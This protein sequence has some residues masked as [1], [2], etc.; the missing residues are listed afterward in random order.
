MKNYW[1]AADVEENGLHYAYA[2]RVSE[3]DN[4][5][6]RLDRVQGLYAANILPS[7]KRATEVVAAWNDAFKANG[8]Y[9]FAKPR[10]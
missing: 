5:K 9:M 2:F 6:S 7:K 1:L 10:F 8:T 4:L 3:N